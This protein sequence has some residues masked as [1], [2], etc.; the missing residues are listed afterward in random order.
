MSYANAE[1]TQ[2]MQYKTQCML[3]SVEKA[4]LGMRFYAVRSLSE[5]AVRISRDL[6]LPAELG[7]TWG[8]K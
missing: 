2:S 5:A 8:N 3:N 4:T 7:R 1:L 6:S